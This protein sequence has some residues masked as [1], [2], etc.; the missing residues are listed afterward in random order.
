MLD[1]L[2][3]VGRHK[4]DGTSLVFLTGGR[5]YLEDMLWGGGLPQATSSRL[6]L[7]ALLET[8]MHMCSNLLN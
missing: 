2:L 5:W 6:M 8:N 7:H 1:E 3:A 4:L